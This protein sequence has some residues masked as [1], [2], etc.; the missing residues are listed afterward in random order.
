MSTTFDVTSSGRVLG[1]AVAS[2]AGQA[3]EVALRERGALFGGMSGVGYGL[4]GYVA[5][6]ARFDSRERYG[7]TAFYVQRPYMLEFGP[8]I[9][10]AR[11]LA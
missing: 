6:K 9:K 2:N 4:F 7:F 1:L 5:T 11:V 10:R 8:C 3:I